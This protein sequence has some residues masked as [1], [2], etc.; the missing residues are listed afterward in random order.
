MI[1]LVLA[2]VWARRGQAVTLAL[3]SLLAV[4]AAVASPAYLR[5]VDLAVASGQVRTALSDERGFELNTLQNDRDSG[6]PDAGTAFSFADIGNVLASLPGFDY[7]YAA[8]FPAIGIEPDPQLA[9][10][11]TYRQ[12]VCPHLRMVSGRCLVGEGEVVIGRATADRLDIAAGDAIRLTFAVFSDDPRNP[13][14]LPSGEPKP[15]VVAGVYDVA[16]P[17]ATYWGSHGYFATAAGDRPGEPVFTDAATLSSMDHGSTQVSID[18][19]ARPEALRV[20]NLPALR[21][22]L[23]QVKETA[24]RIGPSVQMSTAIPALLDRIEAGRAA[25]RLIVPVVAVPLVLLA[26]LSIYL[27]VGYGT[28]GR[29]PELAIVALRGSRW[30]MRWWLATGE[31][32]VAIVAGAVLGCLAGQLLVDAVAA[33]QFPDVDVSAGLSSLR[34]A[35][36]AA[37]AAVLAAVLA[38]RRQLLSPVAELLRRAPAVSAGLRGLALEGAV[39]VLAVVATIQLYVSGGQL[40]GVGTFVPALVAV[41]LALLAARL[42]LPVITRYAVRALRRG[43]LGV[44]LAGFQLSRRPGAARLFTVLVAAVAVAGYAACAVDVGAR[45]RLV[46]AG[47]G[48]GADRVVT[49]QAVSRGRLLAAVAK[50]D[51]DGTFALAASRTPGTGDEPPGL[52]VDTTRLAAV[53]NWPDGGPSA[54]AVGDALHPEAGPPVVFGGQD[55]T[56]DVTASGIARDKPLR[57][58]IAVSSTTG[59]GESTVQLGF[60]V[61]GP[62]TY[63]QRVGVCRDGC[64][65]KGISVS[66]P[67]ASTGLAGRITVRA[68]RTVNPRADALPLATLRDPAR[69]RVAE[70]GATLSSAPDG[71]TVDIQAPAGLPTPIW[72]QP[73]DTAY[74]LPVA[75]SELSGVSTMTG[76]DGRPVPVE[77]VAR[78][79]AVPRLG[80][81]AVLADLTYLDRIATDSGSAQVPQ[82]WLSAAAPDDVLDRINAAGLTV[83]DDISAG[84]LRA[85]LDQQGPALALWFYVLAGALAVAL[86]AGALLMAASVD[87]VRRVEDLSALRAQ[88]LRRG[89]LSRAT[90]WTYPALVLAAVLAGLP[91]AVLLWWLTGWALP[92]AG[93]DPP[94]LPMPR[95]PGVVVFGLTGVAVLVVLAGVAFAAGRRTHRE[96]A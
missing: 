34:Y 2:M 14:Y 63:Q 88:G 53:G 73:A 61:D 81:G 72:V 58:G 9:S 45:G 91:I 7:V 16:E 75:T 38:Q 15:L 36:P 28:E 13:V 83:V 12:D 20:Q 11:F 41:A 26:C 51:P 44:A 64:R 10:R 95:W 25:A 93:I 92:L 54:G 3:L 79:P 70:E 86:A 32:L 67:P 5:A 35:P 59:L 21:S 62:Y 17:S 76:F 29:R 8:E 52:A 4:A 56:L 84:Q 42:A 57:L 90:L 55:V 31:S 33:W 24:L 23:Q 80:T 68:V 27:A 39:A 69:W 65:L 1:S 94:P 43:R 77:V 78:I 60:L 46:Q 48:N 50:V 96:I 85:Q 89:P 66:G 47:V 74:P 82:V 18:G 71:L 37:V 19:R 87:R 49:V 40:T 6:N 22:G 30:W